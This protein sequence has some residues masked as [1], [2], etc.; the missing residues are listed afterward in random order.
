M[1]VSLSRAWLLPETG[2]MCR[3][4][5]S[6]FV[7]GSR[8][9][10]NRRQVVRLG[11]FTRIPVSKSASSAGNTG[12]EF[13]SPCKGR[14]R[15]RLL[16]ISFDSDS[17]L[18]DARRGHTPRATRRNYFHLHLVSDATGDVDRGEPRGPPPLPRRVR[19]RSFYT[20]R[21]CE[22]A[23]QHAIKGARPRERETTLNRT[24]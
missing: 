5:Y 15:V 23:R 14:S 1:S 6:W 2:P 13:G 9:V 18:A 8:K 24:W 21:G 10:H 20:C 11:K 17:Q 12:E 16:L 3:Q 4:P 22:E 19:D 7:I